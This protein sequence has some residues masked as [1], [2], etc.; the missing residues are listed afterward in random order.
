MADTLESTGNYIPKDL[1][2]ASQPDSV[3]KDKFKVVAT[4]LKIDETYA[5]QFQYVYP[6]GTLSEWSP[7]YLLNT[8]TELV[9]GAPSVS[10]PSTSVGSI[11]VTLPSFPTNA[12]RVDI[13]IIGGE[14]GTGKVADYFLAA[15]TKNIA[16]AGGTYQVSLI[17]VT[18]SGIN[19]DPTNTFTIT[20]STAGETVE[21]PT[22]PN[23]FSIIRVLGGIEVVWSGTYANGTFTGFEAIKIYVGT[24]ATA[25]PGTYREAGVMTGN[26]VRNSIIVPVDGTYLQ[27][28]QPV[29]IHARSVNKNGI[30]GTL[31]QNVASNSLGAR[32]AISSD[33]ADAIITNAKLVDDAVTAAKIATSAITETK[34]ANDAVTTPKLVA[35]AITADKIVSSAITADKIATNA[36]TATKILAGEIDVTKLA[37]GTIS[38]NNLEAGTIGATSFIRAGSTTG[39]AR[40]EMSSSAISG[41]PSAGFYIY[42]STGDAVLS[43]PLAGGLTIK[44]DITGSSGTFSGSLSIGS[45][46]SVTSTGILTAAAGTVGGWTINST[47]IRSNTANQISLNPSTPKIALIQGATLNGTTGLYEG[48]TE[49]I[50]IDPIEGIVGPNNG[51]TFKLTPSGQLTLSGSITVTGGQLQTD[52]ST[53]NSNVSTAQSTADTAK[54]TADSAAA[55]ASTAN[56]NASNALSAVQN[57]LNKSAATITDVNNNITAINANGIQLFATGTSGDTSQTSVPTSGNRLVINYEGITASDSLGTS[58]SIKSNGGT[59]EFR[60]SITGSTI[61]GSTLQTAAGATYEGW[62]KINGSNNKIEF[63][64]NSNTVVGQMYT[65]NGGSEVIIQNG[66]NT[67]F[68]YPQSTGYISLSPTSTTIG[69]TNTSGVNIGGLTIDASD[70]VFSGVDV[71]TIKG[72]PIGTGLYYMRNIGM[73]TGTKTTSD[74]DGYRGDIWIQYS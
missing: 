3:D 72:A 52:L 23:G 60:G 11:P 24:S 53:I 62:I 58:F 73:G 54:N 49:K 21:A 37:A 51:S 39:G 36:V 32:S 64:N 44:G 50:T 31:Q 19:G 10:V 16:V 65:F 4:G 35:N 6:D 69:R 5:F 15:G 17:T 55:T 1:Q 66:P 74:T 59:A 30:E 18:P 38:V 43:A 33:L 2:I 13:Y 48:G 8:S 46:F 28:D 45:N 61:T 57:K 42:D 63:I 29:Y 47:Q 56:T 70:A 71:Q 14:F 26:N 67:V 22:N 40:I 41:G 34:I 68:G 9:P 25:T 20:V 12:K 27:Y 7:G